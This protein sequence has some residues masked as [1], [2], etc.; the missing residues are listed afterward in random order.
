M[1]YKTPPL[2]ALHTQEVW[3]SFLEVGRLSQGRIVK[4]FL[5]DETTTNERI[6]DFL[7]LLNVAAKKGARINLAFRYRLITWRA[8]SIKRII[9]NSP[10]HEELDRIVRSMESKWKMT[11]TEQEFNTLLLVAA[12]L[13]AR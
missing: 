7:D 6:L 4:R 12:T 11:H 2:L 13:S 1:E 8:N 3:E 5:A 10:T 9:E